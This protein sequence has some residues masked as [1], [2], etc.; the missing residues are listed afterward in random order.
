MENS[1][2]HKPSALQIQ[3][4]SFSSN[5]KPEVVCIL[6]VWIYGKDTE[7][8]AFLPSTGPRPASSIPIQHGSLNVISGITDLTVKFLELSSNTLRSMLVNFPQDRRRLYFT[9]N[10]CKL[11]SRLQWLLTKIL[12][13]PTNNL[14]R[15]K[16]DWLI[17]L[18]KRAGFDQQTKEAK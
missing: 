1:K 4:D 6:V 11:K 5:R 3:N 7:N 9:R 8:I 16:A 17:D 10:R 15:P 2:C 14:Q 12:R 13:K 18:I